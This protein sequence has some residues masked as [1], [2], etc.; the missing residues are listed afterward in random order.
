MP[1]RSASSASASSF[2]KAASEIDRC[3]ELGVSQLLP[4][5][6]WQLDRGRFENFLGE[7]ARALGVEFRDGA[8][9]RGI[10]LDAVGGHA[11]A[12]EHDG[13][14]DTLGARWVVDASGRAGLLKRKLGLAEA[15]DHD[16]NA[17]WWRVD[18][19]VDPNR[20]SDDPQWLGA[21]RSAGS[22][23]LDQP[24]VRPGLLVLADPAGLGRAFAR[25]RLRRAHASA[26]DD[27]H[28]R[29]GDGLAARAPAAGRARRW[30]HRN[31]GCR[32]SCSC[33]TSPTAASRCFPPIAGR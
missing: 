26:R 1:S 29:E 19:F 25:H 30:R 8:V 22:L 14:A 12:I 5:P 10:E 16:V 9:V 28:A 2:P 6:S 11:I 20:W 4:T 24:H 27:E 15:N 3:T 23:A 32:T 21:L 18:G 13:A 31:T 7:H 33:A 17:V